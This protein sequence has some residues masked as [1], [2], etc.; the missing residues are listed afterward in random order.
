MFLEERNYNSV[1]VYLLSN[2]DSIGFVYGLWRHSIL[3]MFLQC[4]FIIHGRDLLPY[5]SNT[6]MQ[7]VQVHKPLVNRFVLQWTYNTTFQYML[8]YASHKN[9][10]IFQ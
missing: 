7:R 5:I 4:H 10:F 2:E 6:K 9:N 1:Y 3:C 8:I